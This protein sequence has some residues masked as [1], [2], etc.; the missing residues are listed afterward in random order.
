MDIGLGFLA[1]FVGYLL[2][3]ISFAR[4][5]TKLAAPEADLTK[6]TIDMGQEQENELVDV[7]GANAASMVLGLK[8]GATVGILDMAKAIIPMLVI[9]GLF[10]EDPYYLFSSLGGLLGHNW[11]VY[12]GFKGG[13]GYAVIFGS[14]FVVDWRAPIATTLV[15]LFIGMVIIGNPMVAYAAWLWL[16]IPWMI[17]RCGSWE[18]AYAIV[19]NVIFLIATIPEM[20][21]LLRLKRSG[22]YDAYVESMYNSSPRWRGMKKMADRMWILRPIFKRGGKE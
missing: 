21:T 11:P 9:K 6:L 13:R 15:S 19:I 20:R 22:K 3:S 16:M 10:P 14:F 5:I 8:L 12:Y 18:I 4:I 17:W 7:I 1:L 2:G